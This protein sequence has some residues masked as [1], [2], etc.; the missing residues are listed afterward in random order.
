M[1]QLLSITHDIYKS[2][3]DSFEVKGVL[4]DISKAFDKVC[5]EGLIYKSK[6]NR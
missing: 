3:Y 6:Q 5:H 1:N 2:F 4:L